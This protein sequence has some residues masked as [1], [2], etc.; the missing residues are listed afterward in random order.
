MGETPDKTRIGAERSEGEGDDGEEERN[1][2]DPADVQAA[3][4][5]RDR[6]VEF[7]LVEVDTA[8]DIAC[9][10]Q[11]VGVIDG[12]GKLGMAALAQFRAALAETF[13]TADAVPHIRLLAIDVATTVLDLYRLCAL[14]AGVD[15]EPDFAPARPGD[16][17]RSVIDAGRAQRELGWR[18]ETPLAEGI[19]RT[20]DQQAK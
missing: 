19:A 7:A 5:A 2:P 17:R 1:V 11:A 8:D 13:G 12:L 6:L 3:F 18:A 20:W 4:E 15:G 9:L 14:A 16:L 10:D